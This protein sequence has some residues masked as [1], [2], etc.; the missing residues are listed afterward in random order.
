MNELLI[1]EKIREYLIEDLGTGDITSEAIFGSGTKSSGV[2]IAKESGII[3]G[4]SIAQYVYD[5]LNSSQNG[6]ATFEALVQ[7]GDHVNKGQIIAK[8]FGETQ[9]LL[10]GERV[11]LNLIQRMSGIATATNE[12][13]RALGDPKIQITDTRKTAPGLRIFD[14]MAVRLGGGRNHRFGL[15]DAVM[16]KDNHI[17]Y[18]GGIEQ[19]VKKVR[20]N[21][22]HT[23]KIE[24]ETR[25]IEEVREAV[26]ACADIIMFDN[27]APS[28]VREF[29][30]EVPSSIVTECSGGITIENI[31]EYANTGVDLISLGALTHS[32]RALDISFVEG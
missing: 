15:Y 19:A 29:V 7:D 23:V 4:I 5:E 24:V 10:S 31:N 20:E 12:A 3:A 26:Q 16:I 32:V 9:V 1:R 13:I 28:I 30:Q 21:I 22:G 2:F 17:D 6:A 25:N 11:I 27:C 8:A 18:A 14:K